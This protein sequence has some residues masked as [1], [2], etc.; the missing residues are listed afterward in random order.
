MRIAADRRDR[1]G[2]ECASRARLAAARGR[3]RR[4]RPARSRGRRA[5]HARARR[6]RGGVR[7]RA[8]SPPTARSTGAAWPTIVFADPDAARR[9]RRSSTRS[10]RSAPRELLAAAP[11]TTPSSSTTCPLLVESAAGALGRRRVRRRRR[12]RGAGGGPGARASSHRGLT[13]ADARA[14]I[15]AQATDEE[16]WPSPTTWSTTTATSVAPRRRGRRGSGT[17]RPPLSPHAH[18]L[19]L[20]DPASYGGR[21]A[22]PV[23]DLQRTVARSRSSASTCPRGDQPAAIAELAAAHRRGRDG[24]RA[25]R[26]DRHRQV[27]DDGLA[28]R[29]GAAPDPRAWRPTRPSPP[30]WPT[31]SASCCRNNAVEYFVS[32]YDYYQPEAYVPQT[33]TYIEKDSSINEEVER[34]RHSATNSLLTRRDVVVVAT[35]SCIYGLGTPQEYVDRMVR[36]QVGEEIDRDELLRRFVV[37]AVHAQ[38]PRL[39]PRHLPGA[40]RHDR[41]HPGVRGARR[42]ASRC[43]ATRSRRSTR[44]I[45]SPARSSPR[46]AS[47]TIFPATHYVAGPERMERAIGGIEAELEERLA[48]L[49][50]QGKLLEAQRLRMRTTYDLEMMRQIGFCSGIE[51]YS[52]HIDGRDPASAP[53]LPARLLPRRL[54]ARHRRVARHRAADRRDVRGRH[55]RASAPSSSTASGCPS[56]MDNRPLTLGGV[57]RA[58]RPD[59]L[60]LGDARASTSSRAS[61]ATSSSRSSARPASSTRRSS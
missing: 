48:E 15:A 18:R 28:D 56:A 42:S 23:T 59:R 37:D 19:R 8:S 4:R 36:L 57:P 22:R 54:P 33:D 41:D 55:A 50:R 51:N 60:P 20:S 5:G 39:H 1:V 31:S 47:S 29:A 44:C 13:E 53:T 58:H 7:R 45:R 17:L 43:S 9:S 32:Y 30:S 61:T 27:G 16:R 35:V 25:A 26:R 11:P 2:Q 21:M 14:R 52:R 6:D 49:E 24:R 10:W 38:R 40:R 3:R 34:L 12:R 46:T